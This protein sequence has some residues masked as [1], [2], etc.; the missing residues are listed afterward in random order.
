[1]KRV[2]SSVLFVLGVIGCADPSPPRE[3]APSPASAGDEALPREVAHTPRVVSG[4]IARADLEPVLEA[5]LGRFLQGVGV[6]PDLREGRFVGFRLTRLY[7]ADPRF[8]DLDLGPGD[9]VLRVNG[10]S[11]ERPEQ[12]LQVW[13]SLRVASELMVEYLRD[14]ERRELRFAIV[15]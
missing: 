3:P 1:M 9:T 8:A 7:P 13:N 14:G 15:D 5:G 2:L 12:A 6:E 4:E 10:Q 11:I